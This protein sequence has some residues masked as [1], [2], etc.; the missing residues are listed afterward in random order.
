MV[1][2]TI[3]GQLMALLYRPFRPAKPG[4]IKTKTVFFAHWCGI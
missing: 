1:P 2:E 3:Y 4:K